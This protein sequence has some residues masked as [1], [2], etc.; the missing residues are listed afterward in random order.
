MNPLDNKLI[1]LY[2]D[3]WLSIKKPLFWHN[4]LYTRLCALSYALEDSAIPVDRLLDAIRYIKKN[5]KWYSYLHTSK[6]YTAAYLSSKNTSIELQFNRLNH[7]YH[8][9]REVGFSATSFLPI[10]AYALFATTQAGMEQEKAQYARKIF[11]EMKKLHPLITN[12]DDHAASVILASSSLNLYDMINEMEATY[13]SLNSYGFRRGSGL[14]FLSQILIFDP[15]SPELKA[16]RCQRIANRLKSLKFRVSPMYYGTIGFFALTGDAWEETVNEAI[17]GIQLLKDKK[18]YSGFYKEFMLMLT[19]ALICNNHI[20]HS[21]NGSILR[22]GIGITVQ[23]LIA[24]QVA[25]CAASSAA[26]A[27]ASSSSS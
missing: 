13:K 11:L 22:V 23:A 16:E 24:A 27:A 14:Q 6:V 9:L 19:A 8:C 26:A 1:N 2:A 17:E 10:A 18:C 7:C 25:A 20:N 21:S 3:N 12:Y 4:G 5:A 15:S